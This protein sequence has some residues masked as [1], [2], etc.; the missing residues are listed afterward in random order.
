[1]STVSHGFLKRPTLINL[2]SLA[3]FNPTLFAT[4]S[5]L[6]T[7][8]LASFK[9]T[10]QTHPCPV[11]YFLATAFLYLFSLLSLSVLGLMTFDFISV[12]IIRQQEKEPGQ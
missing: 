3:L 7:S 4:L 2:T 8:C 10:L 5:L 6:L 11:F 9:H 12:Q 1:M